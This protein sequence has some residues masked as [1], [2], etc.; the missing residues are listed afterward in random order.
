[1]KL[2]STSSHKQ[3]FTL[4][5]LLVVIAI[6]AILAGML[7]PALSKARAKAQAVK[8][9]NNFKQLGLYSAMW[10]NDNSNAALP[11]ISFRE[12]ANSRLYLRVGESCGS[13]YWGSGSFTWVELLAEFEYIA[14]RDKSVTCPLSAIDAETPWNDDLGSHRFEAWS[15]S[16]PGGW[17]T[18]ENASERNLDAN[19][20]YADN[21]N[22]QNMS[23]V[24]NPAAT[25][26]FLDG[27]NYSMIT[28][29]IIQNEEAITDETDGAGYSPVFRHNKQV[30]A[31]FAD[32]HAAG[33][34]FNDIKFAGPTPRYKNNLG[35]ATYY[36]ELD[37]KD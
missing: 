32:G 36:F 22:I 27:K 5:E 29:R 3:S 12:N 7:L 17:G 11:A 8:C 21:N 14:K 34:S 20:A 9:L 25:I 1:M 31:V 23:K 13:K 15:I 18:D 28:R 19:P 24:K 26:E 35:Q 4:I 2:Q 10:A 33:L 6:I 37:K 16:R 30:N